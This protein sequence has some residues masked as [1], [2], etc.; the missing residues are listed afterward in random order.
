MG[1]KTGRPS[2]RGEDVHT[3]QEVSVSVQAAA[4]AGLETEE[5]QMR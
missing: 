1:R 4:D 2:R 3:E 5:A